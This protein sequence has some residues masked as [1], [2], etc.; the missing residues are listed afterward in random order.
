M[1]TIHPCEPETI[2][3]IMFEIGDFANNLPVIALREQKP[4]IFQQIQDYYDATVEPRNPGNIILVERTLIAQRTAAGIPSPV[5]ATWYQT[6]LDALGGEIDEPAP[7]IRTI[8]DRIV[9]VNTDPDK[10]T[11]EDVQALQKAGLEETDI[12]A[13]SQLI[14]FIHYQARLL[15][16]LN[17]LGA[18]S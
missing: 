16:G 10:T 4:Q 2:R 9:L 13:V 17:A 14:A 1:T 15:A 3:D 12:I 5:L 6:R 11:P 8:L 7:R 18:R